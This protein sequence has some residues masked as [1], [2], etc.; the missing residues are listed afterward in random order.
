ME[1][2]TEPIRALFKDGVFVPQEHIEL[3][4]GSNV[5]IL[6][7]DSKVRSPSVS[8]PDERRRMMDY[9]IASFRRNP[10]PAGARKL[11]RDELHERR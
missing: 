9:L 3:T 4:D 1:I 11:T 10:I 8:D 6:V 7:R 2:S 5:E